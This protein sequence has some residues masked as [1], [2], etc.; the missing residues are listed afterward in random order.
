MSGPPP[1]RPG[2][3]TLASVNPLAVRFAHSRVRPVFSGCGRRLE[4]TLAAL[5]CGALPL[6]S[7]PPMAVLSLPGGLLVSLNNR[8]LWVLQAL[9]RA[10][11]GRLLPGGLAPARLRAGTRAE[12][13]RYTF[14][15]CAA[16]ATLMRER[17][18]GDDF[19]AEAAPAATPVVAAAPAGGARAGAGAAV[20]APPRRARKRGQRGRC[21]S[22]SSSSSSGGGGGAKT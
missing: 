12:A 21:S 22:S 18:G 4:A 15:R 7:L 16:T 6:A 19:D 9:A 5:S 3:Q 8:R 17:G 2:L 14:E 13:E 20:E 11:P 1:E 10:A